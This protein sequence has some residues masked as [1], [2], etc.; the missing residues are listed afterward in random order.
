[1]SMGPTPEQEAEQR[2]YSAG[3]DAASRQLG[4]QHASEVH[5]IRA[6]LAAVQSLQAVGLGVQLALSSQLADIAEL[7]GLPRD[8]EDLAIPPA[9]RAL[10]EDPRV[11]AVLEELCQRRKAAQQATRTRLAGN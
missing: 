4:M 6:E 11:Q 5:T 8:T 2:G 3:R 10:V 1:M 7:V 9:V